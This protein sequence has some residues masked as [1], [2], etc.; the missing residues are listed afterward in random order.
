MQENTYFFFFFNVYSFI[1][2]QL[3][4]CISKKSSLVF[5]NILK[6]IGDDL[7]KNVDVLNKLDQE[8]GDGD[9]GSTISRFASGWFLFLFDFFQS[10]Y[11]YVLLNL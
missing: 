8:I 1:L 7:L 2:L 9:N 10:N 4:T 5:K 6:Q 11:K 3:G